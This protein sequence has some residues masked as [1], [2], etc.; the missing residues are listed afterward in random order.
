MLHMKLKVTLILFYWLVTSFGSF[1]QISNPGFEELNED[2]SLLNWGKTYIFSIGID[3]SG[4]GVDTIQFDKYLFQASEDS[5]TG[6]YALDL[7][8]AYD[9]YNEYCIVGAAYASRD[10]LFGGFIET[11]PI[12]ANLKINNISFHYKYSSPGNDF[13]S[14]GIA[15]FDS[16]GYEIGNGYIDLEATDIYTEVTVP[17]NYF[18]PDSAA[19][20][21]LYFT[22][23]GQGSSATFGT[24]MLVDDVSFDATSKI[25][26]VQ[27]N[28]GL[29]ELFPN[30]TSGILHLDSPDLFDVEILNTDGKVIKK[31]NSAAIDITSLPSGPY[32]IRV[33][34]EANEQ[35]FRVIKK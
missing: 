21:A 35:I 34:K 9:H 15:I 11:Y 14:C 8:N 6:N 13:G 5:R 1:G 24:R 30:P 20:Y 22:N 10:N 29:P 33:H 23:A 2:G 31:T 25:M 32:L 3:T 4:E 17:V 18:S 28:L 27:K 16:L 12:P 26:A 19:T 7:R